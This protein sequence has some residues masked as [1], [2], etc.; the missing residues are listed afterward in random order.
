MFS[1]LLCLAVA[2]PPGFRVPEVTHLAFSPD[3]KTL[4]TGGQAGDLL[5]WDL[6]SGRSRVLADVAGGIT[7]LAF[8]AAGDRVVAGGADGSVRTLNANR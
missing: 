1:T 4:A 5:L 3:G 2:Q 7:A 8:S 6:S